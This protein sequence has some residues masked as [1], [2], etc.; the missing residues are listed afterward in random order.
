MRIWALA[1]VHLA[2]GVPSKSMEVFGPSWENY[3][4]KIQA[5]W[6]RLVK[7]EDIVLIPGDISWAIHMEDA[8][9]DLNWIH[10]LPGTKIILKGNH[11]YWW[12]SSSKL[13]KVLP[14]S[15]HFIYNNALE[16]H[17]IAFGGT[18]LWD[19]SEFTYDQFIEY[20]DNPR[21]RQ[22]SEEELAHKTEEDE[23]IFERE[24]ERLN[25][26]LSQLDPK[27][28][29]RIALVHY[30]PIGPDLKPS[31][32]SKILEDHQIDICVFGHMH[33]VKKGSLPL[34][35][36]RGVRYVFTAADY[37]DFEPVLLVSL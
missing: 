19:T 3:Q 31:R 37:L 36:A 13:K 23:R 33:N 10:A 18:R 32:A 8:L 34:G 25:L 9:V 28:S 15:I 4:N 26:S 30:P 14:S 16:M 17:G 24:L 11:D 5:A 1:D 35:E 2:F 12:P 22:K 7:A 20:Q 29:L 27:A 6:T 21:V